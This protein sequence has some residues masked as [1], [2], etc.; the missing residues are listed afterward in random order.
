MNG[1]RLEV[2]VRVGDCL[3]GSRDGLECE[4]IVPRILWEVE[5]YTRG[6]L[7]TNWA[8]EKRRAE[9]ELVVD[10]EGCRFRRIMHPWLLLAIAFM[11]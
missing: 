5:R 11:I 1:D 6:V 9:E 8:D 7:V 4:K 2:D 3:S 10:A